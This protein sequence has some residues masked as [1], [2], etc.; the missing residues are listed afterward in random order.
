MMIEKINYWV[1]RVLIVLMFVMTLDVLWG[2]FTRYVVGSQ[3]GWT[4]EL[5]RFLLIWIGI[6]GTAYASGKKMH[7]SIDLLPPK[8]GPGGQQNLRRFSNV[9][10]LFFALTVMVIG[11]CR[12]LYISA[13]L[14]QSSAALSIPMQYVYIVIPFSGLLIVLYK[15][16]DLFS[17]SSQPIE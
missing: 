6:L 12:L 2:V 13:R 8:L 17:P 1:G 10:V 11:G 5:A 3:A 7:L 16:L 9:M 4:E 15:L 14:G